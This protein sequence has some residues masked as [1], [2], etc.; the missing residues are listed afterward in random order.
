ML[1]VM[2][3]VSVTQTWIK[4]KDVSRKHLSVCPEFNFKMPMLLLKL[5]CSELKM[6]HLF[7]ATE[8]QLKILLSLI[9]EELFKVSVPRFTLTRIDASF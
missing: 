2:G 9:Q 3:K 1:V 7:P 5:K 4:L 6:W 8:F